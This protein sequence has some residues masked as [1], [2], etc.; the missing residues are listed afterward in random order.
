[1]ITTNGKGH[2]ARLLSYDTY[3]TTPSEAYV[4]QYGSGTTAESASDTTIE[5]YGGESTSV[6]LSKISLLQPND[7]L[8]VRAEID[9]PSTTIQCM[10]V[11][12]VDNDG[13]L[14]AREVLPKEIDVEFGGHLVVVWWLTLYDAGHYST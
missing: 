5:A 8:V 1:M 3:D 4:I 12:L 14:I 9:A 13:A 7:T 6:T 11:C 10:E 2:I